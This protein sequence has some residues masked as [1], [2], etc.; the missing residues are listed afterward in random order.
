MVALLISLSAF[1]DKTSVHEGDSSFK[2]SFLMKPGILRERERERER[3]R[4]KFQIKKN[5]IIINHL[6]L[7]NVKKKG[8][9]DENSIRLIENI[10]SRYQLT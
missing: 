9:L 10:D 8:N 5:K 7:R 6:L 2:Y 3:E 4:R 1:S